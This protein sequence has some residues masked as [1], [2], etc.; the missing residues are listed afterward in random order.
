MCQAAG[1]V[2]GQL[3]LVRR[4][5]RAGLYSLPDVRLTYRGVWD[6]RR[7]KTLA[8]REDL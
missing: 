1:G 8:P 5:R 4:P 6:V 3:E 2:F 7:G